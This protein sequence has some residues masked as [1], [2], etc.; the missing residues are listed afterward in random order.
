[1]NDH[2]ETFAE[3]SLRPG[4]TVLILTFNEAKHIGRCLASVHAVATRAVVVD[5]GSTD[6]TQAIAANAG[7]TVY[8]HPWT[9]HGDQ[10]NWALD[11]V[12]IDTEWV[13]RL[14]A[15]EYIDAELRS[16]ISHQLRNTPAA[17]T[18]FELR[19]YVIFLG[20]LIRFGGGVSPGRVL[21][22][23]RH[24]Q[25]VCESRWMDEHMIL[26][27]GQSAVLSGQLTDHNLNT[28]S[29]WI[30][31]HNNYASR[32]AVELLKLHFLAVGDGVLPAGLAWSARF[33]RRLK[34]QVYAR[35]PIGM[36]AF[37]YLTY[38]LVL[39]MGVLDGPRGW[40]FH[41][42]QA[43]WYR[44]LVDLKVHEVR[45]HMAN[46]RCDVVHAI[47]SVLGIDLASD[48]FR[49]PKAVSSA[50]AVMENV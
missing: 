47:R 32:E 25:A 45:L 15:D 22:M 36:R 48:S 26:T 9:H 44:L 35:L 1:V 34:N 2:I 12:S 28:L 40:A 17:T 43:F 46:E 37:L 31:K 8:F 50:S 4:L 21:R 11:N 38:R 29:W 24:R 20:K 42:L 39:R 10:I 30:V 3:G 13:M 49:Q 7:A 14:D 33:K 16:S 41:F 19:R 23:W 27:S 18:G 5:C 6:G